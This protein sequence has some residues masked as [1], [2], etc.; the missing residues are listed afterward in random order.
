MIAIDNCELLQEHAENYL[1]GTLS[2]DAVR[3]LE[4]HLSR[5]QHCRDA[6][7]SFRDVHSLMEYSQVQPV[8]AADRETLTGP[9]TA[10]A[11]GL[12]E[13]LT[14][15]PWWLVSVA[16]HTL[17]IALAGLVS[18]AV[19]MPRS[20][21]AVI[22]ITELKSAP[23]IAE[24]HE[25]TRAEVSEILQHEVKATAANSNERSNIAV[26]PEILAQATLGDHFETINPEL[27]DTHSAFGNP[28]SESFH[29]V[30]GNNDAAG[31]GGMG[32]VGMEDLIG[33]GGTPSKGKGGGFGGGDGTGIG[34]GSGAGKGAFGS[35]TGG[36]RKL[37]VK[38][39]GGSKET[40]GAVDKGL[41]W[42]A[43][44]QE[45]DGRWDA[46]KHGSQWQAG[47]A[48]RSAEDYDIACTGLALL[49]FLGAGHTEKVGKYKEHVQRAVKFLISRQQPDGK[50][51][52]FGYAHAI[53]GMAL[54]EATGM[55]RVPETKAAAQGCVDWTIKMQ[56]GEG[57]DKTGWTYE[58]TNN[59]ADMSNSGWHIMLLKSAKVAGLHVDTLSLQGAV[60]YLDSC[61]VKDAGDPYGHR[62]QYYPVKLGFPGVS[63][64][65]TAIALL[66]RLYTGTPVHE[67][68][69]A[70]H[71]LIS[72]KKLDL[73][74]AEKTHRDLDWSV[75]LYG[76][77]YN[78]LVLFQV[79]G[80]AW[81]EWN[82]KL[83]DAV[84]L[85]QEAGGAN[86][87]SWNPLG[88]GSKQWGR[89]GQT[90]LN[91]LCMEVYYRYHMISDPAT[92]PTEVKK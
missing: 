60:A 84:L 65:R 24:A 63:K 39:H 34:T 40:E 58:K 87:G 46:K 85:R 21:D 27:P 10:P 16:L 72:D 17:V 20:D 9:V 86:D 32:G 53:A 56:Q 74:D 79:G 88:E 89:V 11:S 7:A 80:D 47:G 54:C 59:G 29:S 13:R 2:D 50:L 36:G 73:P 66:C 90:A 69:D 28:D 75:N 71:W 19:E 76:W 81:K 52:T 48:A 6:L 12:M 51:T 45:A 8:T 26:P 38:M 83:K 61:Q 18:M 62:Y 15:V 70:A 57:S 55:G 22:M 44:N 78:T 49:S 4:A 37:M 77:Y 5:C 68:E 1:D 33:V 31:G 67:L 23:V 30:S 64:Q 43:R 35:R 25:P 14:A 3:S 42:L 41:D 91:I 92:R 82:E